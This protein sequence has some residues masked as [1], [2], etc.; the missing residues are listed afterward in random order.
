[1]GELLQVHDAFAEHLILIGRGNSSHGETMLSRL[2]YR[3]FRTLL[4]ID[5]QLVL[6]RILAVRDL[7]DE[8]SWERTLS[9]G[10]IVP[11]TDI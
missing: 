8:G 4:A 10:N 7:A 2:S 1:V 3:Q 6:R 11:D 9:D 5:K